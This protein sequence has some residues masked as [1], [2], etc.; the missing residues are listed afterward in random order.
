MLAHKFEP[1]KNLNPQH[2]NT[3]M[4]AESVLLDQMQLHCNDLFDIFYWIWRQSLLFACTLTKTF[5]GCQ[6]NDLQ[7]NFN[8]A[9]SPVRAFFDQKKSQ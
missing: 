7:K 8:I 6:V 3:T 5:L 2:G 4:L 1:T 9:M